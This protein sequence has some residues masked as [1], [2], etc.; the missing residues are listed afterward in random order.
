MN[1]MVNASATKPSATWLS[2][3]TPSSCGCRNPRLYSWVATVDVLTCR[4]LSSTPSGSGSSSSSAVTS[5]LSWTGCRFPGRDAGRSG[6]RAAG[7]HLLAVPG[8]P[9]LLH[10]VQHTHGREDRPPRNSGFPP[11]L[12]GADEVGGDQLRVL[13][14]GCDGLLAVPGE[15]HRATLVDPVAVP[16]GDG[17][18]VVDVLPG[19]VGAGG[20]DGLVVV[21]LDD[22]G[23]LHGDPGAR[24]DGGVGAVDAAD[25]VVGGGHVPAAQHPQ[26]EVDKVG[27]VVPQQVVRPGPLQPGGTD[28]GQPV[29][30]EPALDVADPLLPLAHPFDDGE[31]LL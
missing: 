24:L 15:H 30:E 14:L 26:P 12:H 27:R 21:G 23:Q 3:R 22:Q 9:V 4:S 29:D 28:V 7:Q 11:L 16:V 20:D 5:P 19:V 6:D 10:P 25:P 17:E 1:R 8:V 31:S 13:L 18:G 2:G